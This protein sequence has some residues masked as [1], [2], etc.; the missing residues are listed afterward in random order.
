MEV[1]GTALLLFFTLPP[2]LSLF[3]LLSIAP[4]DPGIPLL[5]GVTQLRTMTLNDRVS[6]CGAPGGKGGREEEFVRLYET[7]NLG[8]SC[9]TS[10]SAPAFFGATPERSDYGRE[11]D[12]WHDFCNLTFTQYRNK[13]LHC[14]TR[15]PHAS[16][17]FEGALN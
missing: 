10:T 7:S 17:L 13:V 16:P 11:R 3:F 6:R 9:Y 4:R 1:G 15:P 14:T 8:A 2:F 12:Y 5:L